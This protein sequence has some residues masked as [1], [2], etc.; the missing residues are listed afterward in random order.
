ML[1]RASG[2]TELNVVQSYRQSWVNGN[3]H[4][5]E[6]WAN[7]SSVLTGVLFL[8]E[9]WVNGRIE[10]TGVIHQQC[11]ALTGGR[12]QLL[13]IFLKGIL[14]RLHLLAGLWWIKRVAIAPVATAPVATPHVTTALGGALFTPV[15]LSL[16]YILLIFGVRLIL[17]EMTQVRAGID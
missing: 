7:V 4:L 15:R 1:Y 11:I 12:C 8:W 6:Y 17:P 9:Y 13:K 16:V 3:T 5:T 10:L 14:K 2:S